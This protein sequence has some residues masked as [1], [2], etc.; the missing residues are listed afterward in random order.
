MYDNRYNTRLDQVN[1]DIP[2]TYGQSVDRLFDPIAIREIYDEPYNK[3]TKRLTDSEI[4]DLI[5]NPTIRKSTR[6]PELNKI[7]NKESEELSESDKFYNLS[8]KQIAFKISDTVNN[9]IDDLLDYDISSGI[10]GFVEIFSKEDRL[11]YIGII[12]MIFS[13]CVLLM[14]I[15]TKKIN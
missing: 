12:I 4:K 2:T 3:D 11:I 13:F 9:V 5:R 10:S 6:L 7:A 14:K 1:Q 8:L 15:D